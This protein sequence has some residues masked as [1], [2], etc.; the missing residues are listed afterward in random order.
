[1]KLKTKTLAQNMNEIDAIKN[2]LRLNKIKC[3]KY[4]Y[5]LDQIT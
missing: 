1:M 2:Y 4:N 3:Y 5:G